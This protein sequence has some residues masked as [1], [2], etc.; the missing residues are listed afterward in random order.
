LSVILQSNIKL[1]STLSQEANIENLKDVNI[2][3]S[4]SS[5]H[6]QSL[7][8]NIGTPLYLAPEQ[9]K[10]QTYDE[11]V[12][13]YALGLILLEMCT[14]IKT[15]HERFCLFNDVRKGQKIPNSLRKHYQQEADLIMLMTNADPK[16]RP[17][18]VEIE[19]CAEFKSWKEILNKK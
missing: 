19:K 1:A 13:I 3:S 15:G 17:S 5:R 7:T 8:K 14:N 10:G 11:K 16:S 18:S 4:C 2:S 6:A 12:D 9:E